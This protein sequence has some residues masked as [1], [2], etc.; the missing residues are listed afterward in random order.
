M[1]NRINRILSKLNIGLYEREEVVQLSVLSAMAGES[2]FLLGP[3]GVAKSLVARRL[4]YVFKAGTAFEYLMSRFSTPDEIFGPISITQL[5]N[6]DKYERLIDN[7]LPDADVVFLDE[8]WKAGPSI[9]NTLLT[10]LNEKVFRNG[11]QEIS[12]K[13]KALVAASNE[14]PAQG[15]GLEALWDR[16]LVRTVVE[17]IQAPEHFA[18][19]LQTN[20]NQYQD[21]LAAE[22][23]VT[24]EE[25]AEWGKQINEVTLGED[26]LNVVQVV[27]QKISE[28]NQ[29][30]SDQQA[31]TTVQPETAAPLYVS[32][33]RWLKVIKLLKTSAFLNERGAIDLMDCFLM[34]HC[35]WDHP[36][37]IETVKEIVTD[38]IKAHGYSLKFDL[39]TIR[40]EID[41]LKADVKSQT[42]VLRDIPYDSPKVAKVVSGSR[43]EFY[44]IKDPKHELKK[45][46]YNFVYIK[47]TDF[48]KLSKKD[49][50]NISLF[51]DSGREHRHY[52]YGKAG[53][54]PNTLFLKADKYNWNDPEFSSA[55]F[56]LVCDKKYKK[57]YRTKRPHQ[58]IIDNWDMKIEALHDAIDTIITEMEEY[59]SVQLAALY[60]NL[61]VNPTLAQH[62]EANLNDT[63]NRLFAYKLEIEEQ[64]D[65]YDKIT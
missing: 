20:H 15:E 30:I 55:E 1:K 2:L 47:R 26:V 39:L 35:L 10:V 46:N 41:A 65:K 8:I 59:K 9:Q 22:D 62:P 29:Q 6:H 7:Y 5:K 50:G 42:K 18:H 25:Y 11:Q 17:G 19:Y 56:R 36:N 61:F 49:F 52:V 64:K 43:S 4:K 40:Q 21:Y 53:N 51:T 58:A 28:Y 48:T 23:K 57:E 63:L 24:V 27:R 16:F 45:S 14:L 3:P 31:N 44:Q 38:T 33:R 34:V 54:K 37:Q 13:L 60:T 12:I 32:D